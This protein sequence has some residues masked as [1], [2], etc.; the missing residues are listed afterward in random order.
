MVPVSRSILVRSA[1]L[2]TVFVAVLSA[3]LVVALGGKLF[4]HWGWLVG[5]VAWVACSLATAR[6]LSLA[7][8]RTLAGAAL[9]GVASAVAVLAG[10]H[11]LGEIIAIGLFA[12]WCAR[13]ER[14]T[15]AA[16]SI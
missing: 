12:L 15:G 16:W 1:A 9:A 7:A 5:P 3:A 6:V 2:Q 8:R 11:L 14:R 13:S 10:R 4:T